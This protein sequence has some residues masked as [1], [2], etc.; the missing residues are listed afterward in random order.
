MYM[1]LQF[2]RF[3]DPRIHLRFSCRQLRHERLKEPK[4]CTAIP[5]PGKITEP[6]SFSFGLPPFLLL[7]HVQQWHTFLLR[8]VL[9][10][11]SIERRR[12]SGPAS[13]L[14]IRLIFR[15][16]VSRDLIINIAVFHPS[17]SAEFGSNS[18][19]F[20][21]IAMDDCNTVI[22]HSHYYPNM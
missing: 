2:S 13:S 11:R 9:P 8:L 7:K 4:Q 6:F 10:V 14:S 18:Y 21:P 17:I 20:V 3:S 15:P 16:G 12:M 19:F 5:I 1:I 22:I